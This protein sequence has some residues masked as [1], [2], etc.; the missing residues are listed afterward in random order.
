MGPG[1]S[2]RF[3]GGDYAVHRMPLR[4]FPE[5][6]FATSSEPGLDEGTVLLIPYIPLFL[7]V[8]GSSR[9]N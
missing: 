8:Y 7:Q 1:S 2:V 5:E 4:R 3:Q 6:G 9:D